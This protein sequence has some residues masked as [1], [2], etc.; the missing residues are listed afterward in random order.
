MFAI[1]K[2][3]GKQYRVTKGAK[4]KIE[5]LSEK[6]GND[7]TFNEVLLLSNGENINIGAPVIEGASVNAKILSHGKN[8]KIIIF[9]MKAKKRYQKKQGHRQRYTEV[10]ITDIPAFA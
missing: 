2:T 8:D 1:I 6:E 10:E 4:I 3:G 7:I 9:K 5:Q